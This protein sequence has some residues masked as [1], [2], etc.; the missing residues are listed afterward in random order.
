MKNIKP[1]R[2]FKLPLLVLAAII[3]NP[4]NPFVSNAQTKSTTP[5]LEG[6]V[7]Q[8]EAL[9]YV[10]VQAIYFEFH[11]G[12]KVSFTEVKSSI[13]APETEIGQYRLDGNVIQMEF[14]G[15]SV[16]AT[17]KGN[18]IEGEDTSKNTDAKMKFLITRVTSNTK[19]SGSPQNNS[20]ECKWTW[21]W[22]WAW[23]YN[24]ATKQTEYQHV[25]RYVYDCARP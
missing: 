3:F 2:I 21:K 5:K 1:L 10:G 24:G 9:P 18:L 23:E 6:T 13:P 11:T 7:W 15:F 16:K 22:I 17:L 19:R 12:G 25:Y 14:A 4:N 20:T 8:M